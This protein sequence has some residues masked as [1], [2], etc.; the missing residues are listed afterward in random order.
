MKS[1]C[2]PISPN[3]TPPPSADNS[4]EKKKD[5]QQTFISQQTE[6]ASPESIH[7]QD[8]PSALLSPSSSSGASFTD[9]TEDDEQTLNHRSKSNNHNKKINGEQIRSNDENVSDDSL[10][11]N[12]SHNQSQNNQ[13]SKLSLDDELKEQFKDKLSSIHFNRLHQRRSLNGDSNLIDKNNGHHSKSN[14]EE[15]DDREDVEKSEDEINVDDVDES[16]GLEKRNG[17]DFYLNDNLKKEP[18]LDDKNN[19]K[20]E[21][22]DAKLD[23]KEEVTKFKSTNELDEEEE[24]LFKQQFR[25]HFKKRHLINSDNLLKLNG[26]NS[27]DK[28]HKIES[29]DLK[30]EKPVN[31]SKTED[32]KANNKND[33]KTD[34]SSNERKASNENLFSIY[35]N[36]YENYFNQQINYINGNLKNGDLRYPPDLSSKHLDYLKSVE[37]AN[38]L[39]ATPTD[40][41]TTNNHHLNSSNN[42]N[43]QFEN[44]QSLTTNSVLNNLDTSNKYSKANLANQDTLVALDNL[45]NSRLKNILYTGKLQEP[46][47]NNLTNYLNYYNGFGLN[48]QSKQQ[49]SPEFDFNKHYSSLI[50]NEHLKNGDSKHAINKI[51]LPT[52]LSTNHLNKSLSK[53]SNSEKLISP[54]S[55]M[56]S[57][58]NKSNNFSPP[59]PSMLFPQAP[60]NLSPPINFPPH[61][62]YPRPNGQ[63]MNQKPNSYHQF[64]CNLHQQQQNGKATDLSIS[65]LSNNAAVGGALHNSRRKYFFAY[66]FLF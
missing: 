20:K 58:I 40:Y 27:L 43:S 42:N 64:L 62:N 51:A 54:S 60:S 41:S 56:N 22:L 49:I 33:D 45:Q 53:S 10:Y 12:N 52:D 66:S 29:D 36:F 18:L 4:L 34:Y 47:M 55:S 59:N 9:G 24:E 44:P 8:K 48:G 3:T 31:G 17:N 30:D 26:G 50:A 6:A 32:I 19:E 14:S 39:N 63:T 13:N 15:E 35:K 61:L 16:R 2:Y 1:D 28:I 5:P 11:T 46:S 25:N 23:Q 37:Q 65:N 21:N 7:N 57:G 38:K